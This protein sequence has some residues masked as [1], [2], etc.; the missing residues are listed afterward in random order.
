MHRNERGHIVFDSVK[1]E[2]EW[3]R[4]WMAD[5]PGPWVQ[6]PTCRAFHLS[7][8][9]PRPGSRCAQCRESTK[10]DDPLMPNRKPGHEHIRGSRDRREWGHYAD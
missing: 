6:C 1:E 5:H 2:V 4:Q 10:K 7:K 9:K 3:M 8:T